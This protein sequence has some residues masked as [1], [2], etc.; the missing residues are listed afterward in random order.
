MDDMN[1]ETEFT[2][3][4]ASNVRSALA[5]DRKLIGDLA[6][7]I[8]TTRSTAGKRYR[9]LVPFELADIDKI[10][11]WLG[12]QPRDFLSKEFRVRRSEVAA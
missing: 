7:V 4:V 8:G 11:K 6:V 2:Q 1:S 3:Q 9:G 5:A 10:A 12:Y